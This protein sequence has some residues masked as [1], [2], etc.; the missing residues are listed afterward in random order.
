MSDVISYYGYLPAMFI[1]HDVSLSFIDADR[2]AFKDQYWPETTPEGKHVLKTTMG[3]GI[4]YMRQ[5][6]FQG[7]ITQHWS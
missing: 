2:E 4:L 3:L 5:M 7:L 1:Y 6:D